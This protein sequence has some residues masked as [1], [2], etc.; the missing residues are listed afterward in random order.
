MSGPAPTGGATDLRLRVH[1]GRLAVVRL[2]PGG[3]LPPW[4]ADPGD[5]P[6]HVVARTADET[7][8]VTAADRVPA[9]VRAESD[10]RALEVAGPLDF[11]LTGV[12]AGLTATLATAGVPVF[13]VSTFDTDW[14]LVR[15]G[16]RDAAVAALRAS[17]VRVDESGAGGGGGDR[18]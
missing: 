8:V 11:A 6:L 12:L 15:A 9:G 14:L 5:G 4:A 16:R 2:D 3:P 17:G 7:S 10:F 18:D 13:V 1:P